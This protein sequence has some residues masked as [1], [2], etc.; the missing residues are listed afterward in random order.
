MESEGA[1]LRMLCSLGR[2]PHFEYAGE[3]LA[4]EWDVA[5][6]VLQY[7]LLTWRLEIIPDTTRTVAGPGGAVRNPETVTRLKLPHTSA[8]SAC[9]CRLAYSARSSTSG[10]RQQKPT[11][12]PSMRLRAER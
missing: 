3:L 1:V 9:E 4:K 7:V 10:G 11:H 12:P 5:R 2:N 8:G 6:G